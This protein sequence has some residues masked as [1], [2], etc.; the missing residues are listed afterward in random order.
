MTESIIPTYTDSMMY[1]E[2]L[3]E[4]DVIIRTM[5]SVREKVLEASTVIRKSKLVFIVGSG[6]SYHAGII[7]QICLLNR[8]VHAVAVRSSEFSHYNVRERNGIV[9][10]LIS[11]SG[12]SID[13][14]DALDFAT[15]N[16]YI[17]ISITNVSESTLAKGSNITIVTNAGEEKSV[18]A[19]KSHIAQLSALFALAEAIEGLQRLNAHEESLLG[20]SDRLRI[21]LIDSERISEM[22]KI[23]TGRVVFLGDGYLHAVAME[24]AL[25][26]EESA[27]LVTEAFPIG[28][29]LHGPIQILSSN[30][31]VIILKGPGNADISRVL[32]RIEKITRNI[33]T[34]GYGHS[35]TIVLPEPNFPGFQSI[36]SV[37]P[38]QLMAN[39]KSIERGLNPDRPAR[40]NKIV[41]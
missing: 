31:T 18:A 12:E 22:G 29:Y 34:I 32:T 10:I 24:G 3:E 38:L 28:E 6:T 39:Y 27:N 33:I 26:F 41:K 40:L 30:D 17:T 35:D 11:Q 2:I 23:I 7:L 37:V 14:I 19:T 36:L 9:A 16:N 13:I 8:G 25:K 1:R 21:I 5:N 15:K 4:P 20:L